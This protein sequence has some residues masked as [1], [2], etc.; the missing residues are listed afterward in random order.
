MHPDAKSTNFRL[1]M[2]EFASGVAIIT[3]ANGQERAGCTATA[4]A[5]LSLSPPSLVICRALFVDARPPDAGRRLP[6]NILGA[7]HGA[8]ALRF[9]GSSGVEGESR[10]EEGDWSARMTGAPILA[11]A[12]ASSTAASKRSSSATP[13]QSLLAPCR[14]SASATRVQAFALAKPFEDAGVKWS[15]P[16]PNGPLLSTF[17]SSD[18]STAPV[19]RHLEHWFVRALLERFQS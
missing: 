5:A 12:L 7:Q 9:A 6:V 16:T 11:D 19:D 1:A 17:A 13:M 8:L 2:R 3:C 10:I 4:L 18:S 14:R 15:A